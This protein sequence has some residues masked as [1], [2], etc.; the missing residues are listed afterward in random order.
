[1]N[2]TS[3]TFSLQLRAYEAFREG[4]HDQALAQEEARQAAIAKLAAPPYLHPG[5]LPGF[6]RALNDNALLHRVMFNQAETRLRQWL[7]V[8]S[9]GAAISSVWFLVVAWR[10]GALL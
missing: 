1:M 9:L 10:A 2:P 7:V 6:N 8:I 4:R 3:T 5:R